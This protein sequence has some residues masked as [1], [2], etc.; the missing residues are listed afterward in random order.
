MGVGTFV[1]LPR[2]GS[3]FG[4]R[5]GAESE[6]ERWVIV[7]IFF[8]EHGYCIS[9]FT[10]PISLIGFALE[11]PAK[12]DQVFARNRSVPTGVLRKGAW[13]YI[14]RCCNLIVSLLNGLQL[15]HKFGYD[16]HVTRLRL[17]FSVGL[18]YQRSTSRMISSSRSLASQANR[19]WGVV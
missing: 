19:K 18:S 16:D 4:Y 5:S 11:Q 6:K 8:I 7:L 2:S 12:R 3:G 1:A 14:R 9:T 13:V 10:L 17:V 15:K